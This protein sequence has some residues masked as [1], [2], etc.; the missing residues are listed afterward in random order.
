[1]STTVSGCMV[2]HDQYH[3]LWA[4]CYHLSS[5][6]DLKR[7]NRPAASNYIE[8]QELLDKKKPLRRLTILPRW[9]VAPAGPGLPAAPAGPVA[10]AE[11]LVPSS[12]FWPCGP[13]APCPPGGCKIHTHSKTE[14]HRRVHIKGNNSYIFLTTVF[15]G[16]H[17]KYA[18]PLHL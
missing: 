2:F 12:P 17:R 3:D 14:H 4:T 11:P 5:H 16:W 13:V 15:Y 10:P 6:K 7:L 18:V 9:P 1:M 8:K